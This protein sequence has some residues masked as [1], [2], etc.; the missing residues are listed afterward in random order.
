LPAL[1]DDLE[2]AHVVQ[3]FPGFDGAVEIGNAAGELGVLRQERLAF[4]LG[5]LQPGDLGGDLAAVG[6]QELGFGLA[7]G[8]ATSKRAPASFS[9]P[10]ALCLPQRPRLSSVAT[11]CARW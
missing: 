1:S 5:L 3:L 9:W 8:T 10:R 11:C 6:L 2:A 4:R 7:D